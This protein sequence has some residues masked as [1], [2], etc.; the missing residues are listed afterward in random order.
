M[1]ADAFNSYIGV[2]HYK[3]TFRLT[4][5][6]SPGPESSAYLEKEDKINSALTRYSRGN[7]CRTKQRDMQ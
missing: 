2:A 6:L 7:R 4:A 1:V 3:S 5:S